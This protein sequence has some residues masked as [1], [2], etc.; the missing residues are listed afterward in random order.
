M[1]F[2]HIRYFSNC[3]RRMTSFEMLIPNDYRTD[4][5]QKPPEEPMR[6]LFLLHGYT[7]MSENWVPA[8]LPEKYN[9]AIVMPTAENSFYLNGAATGSAYQ[10]MVGEELPDYVRRTF[11]LANLDRVEESDANPETLVKKLKA[12]GKKIPDLYLCCGSEDF[13]IE[14]NRAMHRFLENEKVPH[15]Y[16]EGPGIHDMVFWSKWIEKA[17]DWM[18]IK[19]LRR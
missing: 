14:P 3:L 11:G 4:S 6:T 7:G 19:P 16:H 18:F 2:F 13:L 17:L 1:A 5:G 10:S 9:F 15:E 12:A 8:G